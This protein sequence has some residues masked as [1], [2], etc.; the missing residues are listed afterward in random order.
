MGAAVQQVAGGVPWLGHVI[1]LVRDPLAFLASQREGPAV[2]RLQLAG[3]RVYLVTCGEAA[4]EVLVST[5]F[6]KGGPFMDTARVLVGNGV[7]TCSNTD[8]RRQQPVMRP[9]FSRE[10]VARYAPVMGECVTQVVDG[11]REGERLDVEASMYGLAARVVARTLIAAPAGREAAETM[12]GAL[13]VLL[14]GMFRQMLVPWPLLHRLPL[15]A[16]RRFQQ[17]QAR[18][19]RA[20]AEVI[21]QYRAGKAPGDDL[22]SL[23]MA[24]RDD[25]GRPL[26]D[27]EVR[28]Q[29]LSVLAAGVETTAS[30]LAWT[31]HALAARPDVEYRLWAELDCELAG[32]TPVFADI[33]RLPYTRQVLLEVLRL[34]P[35]TWMLSRTTL[36]Q[37]VLAGFSVPAGADVIVSPYALQRDPAVFGDPEVFDP[38][39]WLP[40]RVTAAQRQAFTAFG[41]GRR[42]C[43]GEQY[44]MTEAVLALASIS[45]HWQLRNAGAA[46]LQPLPRFLLTPKAGPLLL[47]RR[48]ALSGGPRAV[49]D[50]R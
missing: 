33:S 49:G 44:G 22:L 17:A 5:V 39:R 37:A 1:Q 6:D 46:P 27:S 41:G 18:L 26:D 47:A 29:V 28:D 31:L 36:E 21:G 45:S 10:Q 19:E 11:W 42:K 13:P 43:L 16:N 38:D 12:G 35:P 25:D 23:V 24:A 48:T 34:W 15:P 3:R 32:R 14:E 2:V 8:H 40:E 50:Q 30:L 9:A 20:V 4:R 7:I